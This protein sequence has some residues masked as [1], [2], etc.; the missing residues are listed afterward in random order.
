MAGFGGPWSSLLRSLTLPQG[1]TSGARI[2]LN[3]ETGQIQIY[4]SANQLVALIDPT[5]VWVLDADGSYVRIYDEDPGD[6]ALIELRLPDSVA[7]GSIVPARIRSGT[8]AH[9]SD[10]GLEIR[11]PDVDG[12]GT[13]AIYLASGPNGG[14][15]LEV[16]S[17]Y[18][19]FD[20]GLGSSWVVSG[21][22]EIAHE[23]PLNP[24]T[25]LTHFQV[26]ADG[27]VVCG[28]IDV[29]AL[30][31]SGPADF[32]GDVELN[33]DFLIDGRSQPRGLI[34][35]VSSGANSGNFG[36]GLTTVLTINDVTLEAGRAYEFRYG[37]GVSATN[38]NTTLDVRC[39]C[40]DMATFVVEWYRINI[41]S[42]VSVFQAQG[43]G[44]Y[45]R[46]TGLTNLVRDFQLQMSISAGTAFQA[47]GANRARF[48][49]IWDVGDAVDFPAATV[50]T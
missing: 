13:A 36:A 34:A 14:N 21:D 39:F 23:D 3:G 35:Q 42:A 11:G 31:A 48:F 7:A 6:G 47:A 32:L 27:T 5:G 50:I 24:G 22:W 25:F 33:A 19:W 1:A 18:A 12:H 46:N 9:Y 26:W 37:N 44:G 30:T 20:T 28:D 17:G 16:E 40:V 38:A 4:N 8:S 29:N 41:P 45:V 43:F 10:P 15:V 49:E 2:V